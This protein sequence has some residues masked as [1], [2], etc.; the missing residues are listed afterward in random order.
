MPGTMDVLS[1]EQISRVYRLTDALN[2][3]RDGVIIPLAAHPFGF[4]RTLP[5]GKILI[6]P[7][8]GPAFDPW[9]AGLRERLQALD[10]SRALRKGQAERPALR[11][12]A[13]ALP[14]SGT[15]RYLRA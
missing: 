10:L 12:P 9:F 6:R 15:R 3:N 14:G 13:D 4:E 11:V 7:P 8:A 1:A 2:L 5:D